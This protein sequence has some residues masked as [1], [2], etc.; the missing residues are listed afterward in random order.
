MHAFQVRMRAYFLFFH[1]RM[2]THVCTFPHVQKGN[3][4][5]YDLDKA[6]KGA[7]PL[8]S[9]L[10]GTYL[11]KSLLSHQAFGSTPVLGKALVGAEVLGGKGR[12]LTGRD[13][14][15]EPMQMMEELRFGESPYIA[16]KKAW[17]V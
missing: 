13:A 1:L 8:T 14:V 5:V 6:K 7:L 16:N 10:R 12:V 3:E 17:D 9:A 4:Y 11:L 15:M 2:A